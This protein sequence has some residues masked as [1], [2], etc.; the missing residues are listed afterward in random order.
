MLMAFAPGLT[1]DA[2][3]SSQDKPSKK[4]YNCHCRER[5]DVAIA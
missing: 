2:F 1:E 5:S 4:T 3:T